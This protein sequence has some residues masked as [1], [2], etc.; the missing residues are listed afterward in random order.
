MSLNGDDFTAAFP[1]HGLG[2]QAL[3]DSLTA[4]GPIA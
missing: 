1:N 4:F 2:D 3:R